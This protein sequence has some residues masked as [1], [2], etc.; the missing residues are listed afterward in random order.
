MHFHSIAHRDKV[1]LLQFYK[2]YLSKQPKLLY[3]V[4]KFVLFENIWQHN[5]IIYTKSAQKYFSVYRSTGMY[6]G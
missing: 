6:C 3:D 1:Y 2:R 5:K 4:N